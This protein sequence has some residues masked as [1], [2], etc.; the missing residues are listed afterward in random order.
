MMK[1]RGTIPLDEE[2]IGPSSCECQEP[3][4]DEEIGTIS[5]DEEH[6]GLYSAV[7]WKC[8]GGTTG[9]VGKSFP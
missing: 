1:R 6:V 8:Q 7:F 4:D 9:K 2:Q 5:L 3:D